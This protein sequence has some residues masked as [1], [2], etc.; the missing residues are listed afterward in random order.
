MAIDN[1]D[2]YTDKQKRKAEHIESSYEKKGISHKKAEQLA[3]ATVNKHSGG[4]EKSGSGTTTPEWKKSAA[5]K[6]SAQKATET[7]HDKSEAFPLED[8]P[9]EMLK[10]KARQKYIQ[11]RSTMNKAELIQALRQ[12]R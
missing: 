10:A 12:A 3:W 4:G 11:G 9:I 6:D 5:R 7:K 8:Q 1:K 2:Q